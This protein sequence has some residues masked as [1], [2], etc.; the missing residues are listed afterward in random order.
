M[1]LKIIHTFHSQN[2]VLWA[3]IIISLY[4]MGTLCVRRN[5]NMGLALITLVT[6]AFLAAIF[7]AGYNDKPG[8]N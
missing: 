3:I 4:M 7:T 8:A 5:F 2:G 1:L 6:L